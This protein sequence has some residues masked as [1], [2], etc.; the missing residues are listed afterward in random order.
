MII[1]RITDG[2]GN[3]L[4]QYACGRAL[5]E[6]LGQPL[7]LDLLNYQK[8]QLRTYQLKCFN[9]KALELPLGECSK[10][11]RPFKAPIVKKAL[12]WLR[13]YTYRGGWPRYI[14]EETNK[15]GKTFERLRHAPRNCYLVGY[16]QNL[17]YFSNMRHLLTEEL[18]PNWQLSEKSKIMLNEIQKTISIGVS[19]RRGDYTL[20]HNRSFFGV[21]EAEWYIKASRMFAQRLK[22]PVYFVFCD[23]N[24]WAKENVRFP[25][26]T[27]YVDHNNGTKPHEDLYMLAHCSHHIIANSSFSWWGAWLGW[28]TGQIVIAP[29]NWLV[30]RRIEEMGLLEKGWETL[31][32]E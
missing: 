28:H 10:L 3:Q 2:L 22:D 9:I 13:Q 1:A 25:G 18:A 32:N 24:D 30:G 6:R 14:V 21:L 16:W 12:F 27:V 8:P 19:I 5:A 31:E 15:P 26:K 29:H 7:Y 20:A 17:K 23:D 4:F 11:H